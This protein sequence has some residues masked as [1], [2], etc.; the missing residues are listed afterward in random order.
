MFALGSF[1][2]LM[3]AAG[4]LALVALMYVAFTL[5][6]RS[7]HVPRWMDG[8][9]VP[10][11]FCVIL[12]GAFVASSIAVVSQ[13]FKLPFPMWGDVATALLIFTGITILAVVLYR[14]FSR[15]QMPN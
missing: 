14:M 11:V 6:Y 3:S 7:R 15:R 2:G 8:D 9:V 13:A 10:M 1:A 5:I 12:T 4:L